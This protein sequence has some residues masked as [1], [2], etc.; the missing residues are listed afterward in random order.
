MRKSKLFIVLFGT[1]FFMQ[2]G[3]SNKTTDVKE[4]TDATSDKTEKKD[5]SQSKDGSGSTEPEQKEAFVIAKSGLT[6]RDK[7]SQDG[8][9]ITLL[10]TNSV[11]NVLEKGAEV[12]VKKV[13]SNWYKVKFGKYE[14]YCFGGFLSFGKKMQAKK[15]SEV[16]NQE[17]GG[18]KALVTAKSGLTLRE[19]ASLKGKS[20]L[21]IP[22]NK[23]VNIIEYTEEGEEIEG[24]YGFWV[25][26]S[27]NNKEGYLFSNYLNFAKAVVSAKSGLTLRKSPSKSAA[28][29]TVIPKDAVV[30]LLNEQEIMDTQEVDENGYYWL[31]VRYGNFEGYAFSEFL[32]IS[33]GC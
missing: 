18:E 7:P 32:L 5:E 8:G 20:L 19:T 24:I 30:Y 13:K 27:F 11:V 9:V 22:A 33:E 12:E 15:V 14:G 6:L 26:V 17:G 1:I 29:I 10:A 31:K 2:C 4:K 16:A 3:G 23:E 21:T 28:Q 25:K